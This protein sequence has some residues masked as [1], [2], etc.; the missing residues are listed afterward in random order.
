M[1]KRLST[2]NAEA[3]LVLLQA[4]LLSV[5]T[6]ALTVIRHHPRESRWIWLAC[7]ARLLAVSL[8][9]FALMEA[10]TCLPDDVTSLPTQ[11]VSAKDSSDAV[12]S[13]LVGAMML[14]VT[15][16]VLQVR[17]NISPSGGAHLPQVFGVAVI[18]SVFALLI[19]STS[20]GDRTFQRLC[21]F[22]L[23]LNAISTGFIA[24]ADGLLEVRLLAQQQPPQIAAAHGFAPIQNT[25]EEDAADP[26]HVAVASG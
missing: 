3:T 2:D 4:V 26:E 17:E 19:W 13:G 15:L 8:L 25:A 9:E 6:T 20:D 23:V 7:G 1:T 21:S 18:T 12:V 10:H 24:V 22:A 11:E 5:F 16:V 14:E